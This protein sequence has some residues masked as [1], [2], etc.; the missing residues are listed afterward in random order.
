M[1]RLSAYSGWGFVAG[2]LLGWSVH[3]LFKRFAQGTLFLDPFPFT[4]ISF[5]CISGVLTYVYHRK[6]HADEKA[7]GPGS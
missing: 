4:E 2:M 5:L 3:S 1:P 7:S 6:K